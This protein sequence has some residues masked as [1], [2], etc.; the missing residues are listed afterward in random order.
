M[1]AKECGVDPV[2]VDLFF[3]GH[4]LK[5]VGAF[6]KK[7]AAKKFEIKMLVAPKHKKE[8]KDK[9]K[10]NKP[11]TKGHSSAATLTVTYKSPDGHVVTHK[12][13]PN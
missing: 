10:N 7:K 3:K 4:K 2:R 11:G 6:F 5:P 9:N 13:G 1:V 8:K 12:L